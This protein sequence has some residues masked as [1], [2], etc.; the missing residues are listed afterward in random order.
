LKTVDYYTLLAYNNCINKEKVFE[1]ICIVC[2]RDCSNSVFDG[3][4]RI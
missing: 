3:I 2:G 1:Y 4:L